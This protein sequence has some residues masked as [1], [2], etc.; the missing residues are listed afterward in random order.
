[1]KIDYLHFE[2]LISCLC[3]ASLQ[4][5]ACWSYMASS[6]LDCSA[7]SFLVSGLSVATGW[8]ACDSSATGWDPCC[9]SHIGVVHGAAGGSGGG[10]TTGGAGCG[11]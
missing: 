4:A 1:M 6:L 10:K 8:L 3:A 7:A 2:S 9:S 5:A 11:Q